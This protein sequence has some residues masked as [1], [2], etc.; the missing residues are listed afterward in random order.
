MNKLIFIDVNNRIVNNAE[1]AIRF[2]NIEYNKN[3]DIVK[4]SMGIISNK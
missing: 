1:K 4:I 2:E 3:G